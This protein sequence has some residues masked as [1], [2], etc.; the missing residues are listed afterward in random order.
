LKHW[1][2]N[3]DPSIRA[4][5]LT[6]EAGKVLSP[7]LVI[8]GTRDRQAPYGGGLEWASLLPGARLLTVEGAAHVPWIEAPEMV[9]GAIESFLDAAD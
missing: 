5:D 3:I 7:A 8:H 1:M 2:E 9:F 4:L 6:R